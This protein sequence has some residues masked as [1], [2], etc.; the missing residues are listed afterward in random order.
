MDRCEDAESGKVR[1]HRGPAVAQKRSDDTGQWR[2]TNHARC[3]DQYRNDQEQRE[4]RGEKEPVV[5]R[6]QTADAE[7]A[8]CHNRVRDR[9]GNQS[10]G[11][12]LLTYRGQY[13]IGVAGR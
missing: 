4:G 10:D 13:E 2:D 6:R 1:S 12:E 11:A 5:I 8:L 3:H 9:D 7:A